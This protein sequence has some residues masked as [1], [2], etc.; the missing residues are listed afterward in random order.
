MFLTALSQL[1]VGVHGIHKNVKLK[2]AWFRFGSSIA[3][4]AFISFWGTWGVVGG[5]ALAS[6]AE[7]L[8]ALI[9]GFFAGALTMATAVL[10]LWKR[11]PL[12]K[13]IPIMAP[14]KV[15]E[16]LLKDEGFVYTEKN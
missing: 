13:G 6:G 16:E 11:S 10:A 2:W 3:G 14:M 4:T 12:T 15:E 9:S 8:L 5:G 7:P 1:I